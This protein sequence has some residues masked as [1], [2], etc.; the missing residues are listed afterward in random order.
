VLTA[1]VIQ[2]GERPFC[3]SVFMK[4]MFIS[5]G[6]YALSLFP[7]AL[8][9]HSTNDLVSGL[10][11]LPLGWVAL[12]HYNFAWLANVAFGASFLL[13]L[14]GKRGFALSSA[15]TASALALQMFFIQQVPVAGSSG[16]LTTFTLYPGY[17]LWLAAM[18]L[19]VL[20]TYIAYRGPLK[21]KRT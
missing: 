21:P 20:A 1:G 14:L 17:F 9:L 3:Y 6:V 11:L 15:I 16:G 10:W 7:P 19:L 5:L 2:T 8:Y 18:L 13:V 12:Y 4:L